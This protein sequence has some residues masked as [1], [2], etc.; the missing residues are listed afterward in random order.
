VIAQRGLSCETSDATT[1]CDFAYSGAFDHWTVPAGVTVLKIDAF[2]AAGASARTTYVRGG[3][4]GG[5]GGEYRATLSGI[6]PG[7]SLTIFV[8]GVGVGARGGTAAAPGGDGRKELDG[9]SGGGGGA[10]SVSLARYSAASPLVIAGGGG[11]GGGHSSN[12]QPRH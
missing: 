9:D 4:A 12:S 5:G 1:T 11:G 6:Q 10:T 7:T 2:G 3:G 8:G